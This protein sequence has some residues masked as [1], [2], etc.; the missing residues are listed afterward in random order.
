MK[1]WGFRLI[2]ISLFLIVGSLLVQPSVSTEESVVSLDGFDPATSAG[3][4]VEPCQTGE[5]VSGNDWALPSV[6]EFQSMAGK[7][8]TGEG[9]LLCVMLFR[10]TIYRPPRV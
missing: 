4:G 6:N 2:F 7:G 10:E 9:D 1:S 8:A 3:S 5:L